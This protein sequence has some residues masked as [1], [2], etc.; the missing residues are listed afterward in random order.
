MKAIVSILS[1]TV[2]GSLA[3]QGYFAIWHPSSYGR[4][5]ELP[6]ILL[7]SGCITTLSFLVLIVPSFSWLRRSH[8][9]VSPVVGF[10][11]GLLL[12]CVVMWL[13]LLAVDWP[14]RLC[15]LVAGSLAGAIG[16]SIYAR[17]LFKT[18]A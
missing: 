6:L 12:G 15:D 7:Y 16:V 9:T 4:F 3:L 1:A 14:V 2:V 13:Y 17:L 18:S 10:L 8:R 5:A 11:A